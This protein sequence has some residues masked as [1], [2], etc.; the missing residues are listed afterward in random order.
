M[1]DPKFSTVEL[2]RRLYQSMTAVA[3][4]Q[5]MHN[6]K[7]ETQYDVVR[8]AMLYRF[9][10]EAWGMEIEKVVRWPRTWWDHVKHALNERFGWK[11]GVHYECRNAWACFPEVA[12]QIRTRYPTLAFAH[13]ENTEEICSRQNS[14]KTANG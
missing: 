4:S 14:E 13:F 2:E 1:Y 8:Q 11:L 12:Q 6:A 7:I 9:S 5:L 10:W 3:Q